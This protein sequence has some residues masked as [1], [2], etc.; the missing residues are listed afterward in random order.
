MKKKLWLGLTAILFLSSA[1]A[2]Y[3]YRALSGHSLAVRDEVL[4]MMPADATAVVFV[5]F[6][7]LRTAPFFAKLYSWAPQPQAD[8]EYAQFL[9]DTGFDYER[10]LS[11]IAIAIRKSGQDSVF[12]AVADGKFDKSKVHRVAAK[13]GTLLRTGGQEIFSVPV[14]GS[15]RKIS[16]TFLRSDRIALTND[17]DPAGSLTVRK[18]EGDGGDWRARF[19]RLAGSPIFAVIRQDAAAGAALAERAP[20]GLRSPQLSA[21]LD[22][23]QWITL[24]VKP[25][26]DRL[27]VVAEGECVT[28][29]TTH[30]LADALNGIAL[31]ADAGLNDAKTRRQL[32][33]ALRAAYLDLLKSADVSK[34]DR[35]DTKSVRLAFEITP[36]LLDAASGSPGVSPGANSS[37]PAPGNAARSKKG[38]T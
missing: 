29:A 4:G 18:R 9:R 28:E 27:H 14:S 17:T 36:A 31:L 30:Q 34:I 32:D 33:P 3:C 21:L 22:Q 25:E 6:N 37:R 5:D 8:P 20:G 16:F 7:E 10:D 23:L 11:R 1:A 13:N 2:F 12:F 26:S 38:H 15:T 24:A 19:E 35:G